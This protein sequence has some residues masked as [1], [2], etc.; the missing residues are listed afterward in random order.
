[1]AK[2]KHVAIILAAGKGSRMGGTIPKQFQR[3]EE[4]PVICY[5]MEAFEESFIDEIILVVAP[6]TEE[7]CRKRF[8]EKYG[9]SKVTQIVGGGEER[10]DSVYKA[11]CAIKECDYVY[12][13]DGAR[14]FVDVAILLRANQCVTANDACAAGMPVRDTVK[15][16][17]DM[18]FV[19]ETPVRSNVW[20][21][22]TPQAFSYAVIREAYDKL[23]EGGDLEDITDDAM[24]VER[25]LDHPVKLFEG[26]YRNM[27]I[28]TP[29]DMI[30]AQM[31]LH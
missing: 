15:I 22:Q 8:V 17:D 13:H 6:G 31:L 2:K 30:I 7:D 21:I 4:K 29:Q 5:S 10:Y 1:M 20:Q 24:V 16:A 9:Y 18:D 28:T 26:S 14:P 19:V 12:I 27:K 25:M 3:L 11:L 23:F